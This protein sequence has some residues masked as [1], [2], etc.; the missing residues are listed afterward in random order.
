M[1]NDCISCH[2]F[3]EL[4]S[5][6]PHYNT[7]KKKYYV[8]RSF[9]LLGLPSPIY[10]YD[11]FLIHDIWIDNWHLLKYQKITAHTQT[12][13]ASRSWP[14]TKTINQILFIEYLFA[15]NNLL[16]KNNFDQYYPTRN[17][18]HCVC[19]PKIWNRND[20]GN[21]GMIQPLNYLWTWRNNE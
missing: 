14:W 21:R 2:I 20:F 17:N 13:N 4:R 5:E 19:L 8:S 9:W 7:W 6:A 11:A 10:P 18:Q 16:K 1:V 12:W 3:L 15:L